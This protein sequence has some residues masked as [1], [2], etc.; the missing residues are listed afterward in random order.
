MSGSGFILFNRKLN[1]EI[2]FLIL[3]TY[4]KID[5]VKNYDVPKGSLHEGE[6]P[7]NGAI[8]E[9]Y[10]EANLTQDDIIPFLDENN[11]IIKVKADKSPELI[12]YLAR[13][14]NKA[15]D[16]VK[17]KRNPETYKF[18]HSQIKYENADKCEK[19]CLFYLEGIFKKSERIIK[20]YEY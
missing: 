8:R 10:E 18:E 3:D 17:I 1:G 20:L 12:L 19:V 4:P 7:L 2:E 15:F 14:K 6:D 11:N 13:I 5:K 16:K 9:L